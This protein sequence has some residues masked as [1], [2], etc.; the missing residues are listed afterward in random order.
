MSARSESRGAQRARMSR[1]VWIGGIEDAPSSSPGSVP[2]GSCAHLV[3]RLGGIDPFLADKRCV[4]ADQ[5]EVLR[6]VDL[7][8]DDRKLR[9]GLEDMVA[10]NALA[11]RLKA[12]AGGL[13]FR[14]S[15]VEVFGRGI[16][17]LGLDQAL[18][19]PKVRSPGADVTDGAVRAISLERND[20]DDD[21]ERCQHQVAKQCRHRS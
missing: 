15:G 19:R 6:R 13:E 4:L 11:G 3:E 20:R 5:R 1:D 9:D 7:A 12:F 2:S 10:R 21:G 16:E 8:A 18:A 17:T 14:A